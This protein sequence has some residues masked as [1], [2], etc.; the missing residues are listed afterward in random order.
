MKSGRHRRVRD[1]SR[2]PEQWKQDYFALT[3]GLDQRS[4]A[5]SI[6]PGRLVQGLNIE[7]IFGLQGYR[8]IQGNERFDGRPSPSACNFAAQPFDTGTAAITAGQTV[9]STG[10]ASALVVSVTVTSGSFG[11]GNAAGILILTSLTGTWANNDAIQVAAVTKALASDETEPGSPGY[12]DDREE[13]ETALRAARE[14]LRA[15]I[16]KPPGE[17]GILGVA[18]FD[19]CVYCVR[20]AVGGASATLFKSSAAGW[21][22]IKTFL[23]PGTFDA[24]GAILTGAYKFE[25]A[26]F[27]GSS[28]ETSLFG[29]NGKGRLFKVNKAGT[30]LAAAPIYGSEGTSLSSLTIGTGA[31]V[32]TI[33]QTLRS[34]LSADNLTIWDTAN[35]GNWMRGTVT[36]YNSGTNTLTMNIT[37]TG[38]TGTIASWEIGETDYSDKPYDLTEHKDHMFLAYPN[39][40]LQ[41]SNLGD[42]LGFTTTAAL[43]GI[44]D[45][46]TDLTSLRGE[47]LGIFAISKIKLLRGSSSLDWELGNHTKDVGAVS[48]TAQDNAGNALFLEDR[49]LTCLQATQAFG[50]FDSSILSADAKTTLDAKRTLVVGSRMA[51]NNYQYRLYFSDGSNLRCTIKTGNPVITPKDVSFSVSVYPSVPTCF[52]SGLIT[53]GQNRMFF[54]SRDGYVMEEDA[55]TSFDGEEIPYVARLPFNHCKTPNVTKRWMQMLL[56][57]DSPDPIDLRFRQIFNYDDGELQH[58]GTQIADVPG[59]GG[60]FDVDAWDS[61]QFDLPAVTQARASIDGEGE[62]MALLLAFESDFVRPVTLQGLLTNFVPNEIHKG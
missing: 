36:T 60:Q 30:Y 13:Y 47:I 45:D 6:K 22:T 1:H 39:G 25:V 38:G 26:N 5:L 48:G 9:T 19:A 37:A 46:L 7:E 51:K 11:G 31:K 49:G 29:V 41:S 15:L 28:T 12:G 61:F 56:E 53:A 44:G 3:G 42:P 32:L 40:Q 55:G 16:Q 57:L 17:G 27:S 23:H 20:N 33:V 8:T 4:S 58:G 34:W 59:T 50:D 43:F 18:V 54:G 2:W 10:G 52:A 21:V 14:A 62:N 35:P 24:D